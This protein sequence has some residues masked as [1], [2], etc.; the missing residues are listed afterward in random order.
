MFEGRFFDCAERAYQFGKPIKPEVA[1]WLNAAPSPDLCAIVAHSLLSYHIRKDWQ[2]IKIKRMRDVLYAKF[3][4]NLELAKQLIETKP[5]ELVEN[6]SN[7]FWG[8]G[9]NE[10]GQNMLGKL[11]MELRDQKLAPDQ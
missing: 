10:K 9:K 3:A 5:A 7:S 4:Q 8:I 6:S 11:L 2:V 1:E